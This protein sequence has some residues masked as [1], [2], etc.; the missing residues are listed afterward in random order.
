MR[1]FRHAEPIRP[2]KV[3]MQVTSPSHALAFHSLS[4]EPVNINEEAA[5]NHWVAAWRCSEFKLR[6][7]VAKVGPGAKDVGTELGKA[8]R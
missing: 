4:G 1:R 2:E 7:A 3:V 6:A 8:A 5:V